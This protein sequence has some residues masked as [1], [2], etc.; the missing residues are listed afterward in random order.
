[1]N[2]ALS[3]LVTSASEAP[4]STRDLLRH[5]KTQPSPKTHQ[6]PRKTHSHSSQN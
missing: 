2:K 4:T 1:M 3:T 5:F 6:S